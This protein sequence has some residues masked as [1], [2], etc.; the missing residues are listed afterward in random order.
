MANKGVL[1]GVPVKRLMPHDL[2]MENMLIV[3]TTELNTKSDIEKFITCLK[4]IL[5]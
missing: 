5:S 1:A 2:T 3:A 4:E